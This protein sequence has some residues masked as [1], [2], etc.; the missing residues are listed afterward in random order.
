MKF[1]ELMG[2]MFIQ[3]KV[4]LKMD[5]FVMEETVLGHMSIKEYLGLITM[6]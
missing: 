2:H 6:R 5:C 4:Q 3:R 1:I